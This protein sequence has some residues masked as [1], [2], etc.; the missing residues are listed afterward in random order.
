MLTQEDVGCSF[1]CAITLIGAWFICRWPPPTSLLC[2]FL[3][4]AF[5]RVIGAGGAIAKCDVKDLAQE[6]GLGC[7][8]VVC[9]LS[10]SLVPHFVPLPGCRDM[11]IFP[12]P[13]PLTMALSFGAS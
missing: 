11:S 2:S 1:Q 8:L 13:D 10:P 7:D 12:L 5:G 4:R 9:I 6:V 3:V